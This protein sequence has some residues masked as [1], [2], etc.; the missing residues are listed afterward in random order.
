[1]SEIVTRA[2]NVI[3]K[4][5]EAPNTVLVVA[6]TAD[7][8]RYGDIVDQATW[9]LENYRAN[10]VI[11]FGH[12]SYSPPVG[13][14]VVEVVDGKLVARITFDTSPENELGRLMATQ[15]AGGFMSTV[16]VG[17]RSYRQ[18][19]RNQLPLDDPRRGEKGMVL[20]DN[21][22]LEISCV[23]IP[24]NPKA[25]AIR[26][27]EGMM[28]QRADGS[29][30]PHPLVGALASQSAYLVSLGLSG[31]VDEDMCATLM[32]LH[33]G[34]AS[35]GTAYLSAGKDPAMRDLAAKAVLR[36]I[37]TM[38]LLAGWSEAKAS[39]KPMPPIVVD[40]S[41][42]SKVDEAAAKSE[43]EEGPEAGPEGEPEGEPITVHEGAGEASAVVDLD[44][45]FRQALAEQ[46]GAAEFLARA[47]T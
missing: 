39:G 33:L 38:Q 16:S 23:P 13:K 43:D 37:Q 3:T 31:E 28:I 2:L 11:L 36:S 10:P 42:T 25:V 46:D 45:F 6:S 8:D 15:Y 9:R 29:S 14:A 18:V 22:L 20:Y 24:A 44:G 27:D 19:A 1:M 30:V 41:D 34:V 5:D 40:G 47:F 35:I 4:A 12:S 17:F 26:S 21:E 7:V 32:A